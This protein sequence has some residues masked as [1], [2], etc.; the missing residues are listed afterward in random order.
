VEVDAGKTAEA[1][2]AMIPGAIIGGRIFDEKGQF[3]SN[4]VVQAFRSVPIGTV[5][6]VAPVHDSK[7]G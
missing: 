1:D 5:S 2:L 4:A 7:G 3:L 6:A